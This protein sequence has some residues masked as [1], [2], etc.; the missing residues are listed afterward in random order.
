[1]TPPVLVLDFDDT[2]TTLPAFWREAIELYRQ[3]GGRV[4]L[5]T[6]RRNTSENYDMVHGWLDEH[7][8]ELPVY[9]TNLESKITYLEREGIEKYVLCDD[10]PIRAVQGV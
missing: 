7:G 8:I 3:H 10:S 5:M 1:M 2:I 6:Q 9:F 4:I